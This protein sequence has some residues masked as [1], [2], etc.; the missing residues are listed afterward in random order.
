LSGAGAEME[1]R[2]GEG[3]ALASPLRQHFRPD[4]EGLRAVA[5]LA[6]LAFHARIPPIAGGFVGVD[7]FYV[8]SGY[9]ITGLLVREIE[10]HGRVAFVAFYARRVRRLL[11]AALTV[12]VVTL[13]L[14]YLTLTRVEFDQIAGDAM[15]A[16]LYVSNVRFAIT[17][18]DY[19]AVG[20][21]QSPLLHYWSLGVEEQF[22][23]FWPVLILL[24]ARA[25]G[26]RR[27]W[28]VVLAIGVASLIASV[29]VARIQPV[30]AFYLL[31]TRAWELAIGGLVALRPRFVERLFAWNLAP[32]AGLVLIGIGIVFANASGAYGAIAGLPAV[33]GAA[34]VIAAGHQRSSPV[35][36][37]LS[38]RIP[39]WLG[40]I[41]YSLYLWH[42]PILLLVPRS[43]GHEG[44]GTRVA[45]VGVSIGV[46]ALSTRWIEDPFRFRWPQVP[47]R[48][49][50]ASG[51]A[52][53]IVLAGLT[54][55][56]GPATRPPAD[57]VSV[58]LRPNAQPALLKAIFSGPPPSNLLPTLDDAKRDRPP[59]DVD[60]CVVVAAGPTPAA[61]IIGD[62]SSSTTVLVVG[63]SK[64]A[65]WV[66]ALEDLAMDRHWRLIRLIKSRCPFVKVTVWDPILDQPDYACDAWNDFALRTIQQEHPAIVFIATRR[67]SELRLVHGLDM[68]TWER[69]LTDALVAAASNHQRVV[70]FADTPHVH[71]D[72]IICLERTH[73]LQRCPTD[74]VPAAYQALEQR[75]AAAAGVQLLPTTEWLC[76]ASRCPLVLG[77]YLLYFDQ[78]HL[79]ITASRVLAP[80][81]AWA[82]DHPPR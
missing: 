49:A 28:L 66:P 12:I 18:T 69:G 27:L 22:Y 11:P 58:N 82:I 14:A 4:V 24:G 48:V 35:T 20:G 39:R 9:L 15:A 25:V 80:Q 74:P 19:F 32:A 5:V 43:I 72:P 8:I 71:D 36:T 55:L 73:L 70:Y 17:A 52:A 23:L 42:W 40:R 77:R 76:R 56:G 41:S 81:V 75:A 45:L 78:Y 1:L 34:A 53:S 33:V 46:A 31:P 10:Q 64:A 2:A 16:A 30:W 44:L 38:T 7:V 59:I 61:C 60:G 50:L 67:P 37:A 68:P 29:A 62:R 3:A 57:Q 65:Q 6:V 47:S 63:D 13:V 79:T 54:A 21:F 26:L 51:V